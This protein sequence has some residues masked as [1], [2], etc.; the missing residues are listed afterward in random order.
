MP[1][2]HDQDDEAL[3]RLGKRLD[4]LEAGRARPDRSPTHSAIGAGYRMIAELIGG[5]LTGAGFGWLFDQA[6]DRY[7][8]VHT[9]PWGLA[10]GVALGAGLSVYLAARTAVRMGA[11]AQAKSGPAPSVPDDDED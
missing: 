2:R 8:H 11:Q 3:R 1:R 5:V 9:G 6:A 4:A 7:G 10:V